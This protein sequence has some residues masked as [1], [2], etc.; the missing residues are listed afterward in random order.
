MG[1]TTG[2]TALMAGGGVIGF[3]LAARRLSADGDPW[4]IGG[5]GS[6]VGV[7]GFA[8]VI[9]AGMGTALSL[10]ALGTAMIGFGAGLFAHATLTACMRAAP[11]DKTGLALGLWGAVQ[12][13]CG[14]LAIAFGGVMRDGVTAAASAGLLGGELEGPITGYVSV[15]LLE[16]LILFATIAA[17][18]PLISR[19]RLPT[20]IRTGAADP[21]S[22]RP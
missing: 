9:F 1:A 5:Y 7:F 17:V 11:S 12:A 22:I 16:V 13:S 2:L 10:F 6:L 14:G 20:P 21:A 8:L 3:I 18:G 15:Y 19:T 4:R